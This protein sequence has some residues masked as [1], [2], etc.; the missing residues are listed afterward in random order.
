MGF[1]SNFC[2]QTERSLQ[3]EAER[4]TRRLAKE[5]ERKVKEEAKEEERK[6]LFW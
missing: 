4:E 2:C 6:V 5:Q 1:V 3:R